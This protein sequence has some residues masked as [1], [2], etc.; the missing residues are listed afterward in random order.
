MAVK[1]KIGEPAFP[2]WRGLLLRA[3]DRL[4]AEM[5]D[6]G[7]VVRAMLEMHQP[8]YLDAARYARN[9]LGNLWADFLSDAFNVGRKDIEPSSLELARRVWAL[10][11]RLV[12]TTNYD[13]V[14]RWAC[15]EQDDLDEVDIEGPTQLLAATR[16]KL[17]RPMIWHL[18]GSI[19]EP[20]NIILSPDGYELLYASEHQSSAYL[21]ALTTLRNIIANRTLLFVGFSLDDPYLVRQLEWARDVFKGFAGP[22]YILVRA[23][24]ADASRAK[25]LEL[26]VDVV[27]FE[28]FGAPLHERLEELG[29]IGRAH[30]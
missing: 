1:R 11:S 26:G 13:R 12:V 4:D 17:V 7:S 2:S 14:L 29:E 19:S 23:R 5:R 8:R 21:A 27:T 3:A 6:G 16:G 24:D 15:P 20:A 28:D 9:G 25:F 30:V 10:N 22:H 18:H